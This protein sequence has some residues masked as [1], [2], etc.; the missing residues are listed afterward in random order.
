MLLTSTYDDNPFGFVITVNEVGKCKLYKIHLVDH[1]ITHQCLVLLAYSL[2]KFYDHGLLYNKDEH[3]NHALEDIY[4][5]LNFIKH[6]GE[7]S[8]EVVKKAEGVVNFL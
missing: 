3:V 8:L 2:Q 6:G 1:D 5:S 4:N 7:I